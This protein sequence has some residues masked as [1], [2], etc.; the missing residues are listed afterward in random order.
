M[1]SLYYIGFCIIVINAGA[2]IMNL[3]L[4]NEFSW[5]LID[6]NVGFLAFGVFEMLYA[7]ESIHNKVLEEIKH[8]FFINILA[9]ENI[10]DEECIQKIHKEAG[11]L[12]FFMHVNPPKFFE[13]LDKKAL[14]KANKGGKQ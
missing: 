6:R 2:I 14:E 9:M 7:R 8:S 13:W 12:N 5:S 10:C 1:K 3:I 11:R 4:A